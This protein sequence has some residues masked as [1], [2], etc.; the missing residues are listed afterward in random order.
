MCE[1]GAPAHHPPNDAWRRQVECEDNEF[2]LALGDAITAAAGGLSPG[3]LRQIASAFVALGARGAAAPPALLPALLARAAACAADF[4]PMEAVQTAWALVTMEAAA[5]RAAGARPAAAAAAATALPALLLPLAAPGALVGLPSAPLRTLLWLVTDSELARARQSAQWPGSAPPQ[6]VLCHDPGAAAAPAAVAEAPPGAGGAPGGALV[7]R[8]GRGPSDPLDPLFPPLLAELAPHMPQLDFA[9]VAAS[10]QLAARPHAGLRAS[11]VGRALVRAAAA[12]VR[13]RGGELRGHEL[14]RLLQGL[15]SA[16]AFAAMT[17]AR[18]ASG[19][20]GSTSGGGGIACGGSSG[21]SGS[22]EGGAAAGD[23][24][25]DAL[26]A[27]LHRIAVRG[28]GGGGG[29]P[30]A[31]QARAESMGEAEA[32]ERDWQALLRV[33]TALQQQRAERDSAKAGAA[34]GER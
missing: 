16:A 3:D 2:L 26:F 12:W 30:T 9:A 29:R 27:A 10:V 15:H 32:A 6:F 28:G 31:A 21:G 17:M 20:S 11:P 5:A 24:S 22:N 18:A 7:E 13:V 19:G 25:V 14:V 23:S 34:A 4:P 33:A 8:A 1:P